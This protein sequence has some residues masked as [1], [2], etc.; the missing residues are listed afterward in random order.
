MVET[1]VHVGDLAKLFLEW[2]GMRIL[3]KTE[4]QESCPEFEVERLL[5]LV[6]FWIPAE[7]DARGSILAFFAVL[8]TS[9]ILGME[10]C[11]PNMCFRPLNSV[12]FASDV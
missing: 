8:L 12:Y 4:V 1:I 9:G 7:S 6:F 10:F 11:L 2:T 3:V 5:L